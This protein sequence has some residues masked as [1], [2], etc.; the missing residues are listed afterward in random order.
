MKCNTIIAQWRDSGTE[1]AE[2]YQST[3]F[4][5]REK[6]RKREK[7]LP[8]SDMTNEDGADKNMMV[9]CRNL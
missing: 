4:V 7:E 6:K 1:V 3:W 8:L 2:K 9:I 5:Q